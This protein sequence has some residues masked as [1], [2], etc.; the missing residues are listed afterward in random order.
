MEILVAQIVILLIIIILG[1]IT[2]KI[3]NNKI[4]IQSMS[5]IALLCVLAAVLSKV[6]AIR[7]PPG[8]PMFV[9]SMGPIIMILIGV[10][11]SPKLA[12]LAGTIIDLIGVLIA[13]AAGEVSMPFFG[14]TL[15]NILICW[16]PSIIVKYGKN[17]SSTVIMSIMISIFIV[18]LGVSY[19]YL[20]T[21]NEIKMDSI[22][23]KLT[24]NIRY[25]VLWVMV[26]ISVVIS[27]VGF[28]FNKRVKIAKLNLPILMLII[29]LTE[30]IGHTILN[31][32]W[33]DIMYGVPMIIGVATRALKL[34]ISL[35]VYLV[36]LALIVKY[37]PKHIGNK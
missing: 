36:I 23:L 13:P 21:H 29:T 35:P 22:S 5:S 8:Q 10:L 24:D 37:L 12:F 3:D 33:V 26:L 9:L 4:T 32:L 14:F 25:I 15:T 16:I 11:Y 18:L 30:I 7:M 31:S 2:F 34:V 17:L 28:V 27:I 19:W 6:L 20:F 1:I